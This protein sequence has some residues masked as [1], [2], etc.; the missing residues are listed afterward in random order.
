M[1]LPHALKTA[2]Q[3]LAV[4][5]GLAAL[6]YAALVACEAVAGAAGG[7]MGFGTVSGAERALRHAIHAQ[8]APGR[9]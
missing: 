9:L 5:G 6:G 7:W 1:T 8:L 3:G 2:G 4:G